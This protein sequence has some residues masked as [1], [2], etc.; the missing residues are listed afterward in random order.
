MSILHP[1]RSEARVRETKCSLDTGE[2]PS[3]AERGH[4]SARM[5]SRYP[6]PTATPNGA[7]A[8]RRRAA[9]LR[10]HNAVLGRSFVGSKNGA[11]A[12]SASTSPSLGSSAFTR[13][14]HHRKRYVGSHIGRPEGAGYISHIA[15]IGNPSPDRSFRCAT[16]SASCPFS[17]RRAVAQP[18]LP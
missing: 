12:T 3:L 4:R 8:L 10:S 9:S 13:A 17:A 7:P 5:A 16:Q 2:T 11:R 18:R 1:G 14:R 6:K 15:Q